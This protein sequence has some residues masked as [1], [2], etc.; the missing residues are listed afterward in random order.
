MFEWLSDPQAWIA[1][2]T[3]T[4][5]EI[6]LGVDNVIFISILAGKLPKNQQAKARR[7]GLILAMVMRILLLFS[8][9]W[10]I[11]L[12]APWFSV[13]GQDISGRDLILLLGGLFLLAKATHEIHDKLEGEEGHGSAK[14]A[15]SF[16]SVIIQIMLL[17]IVFSLDSVITAVGM[18]DDL[19][20][21]VAAVVIAVG[22]M[23][24]SAGAISG[25]VDRHPT[26]KILALSFLI[27]IGVSLIAEAFEQH[28][29]KGYIYFAMAFSVFVEMINLR[30]RT[31][32][33][34]VQ[35]HQPYVKTK[36]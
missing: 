5:L 14:V 35:L 16:M 28:I 30:V 21:M 4:V 24:M 26:V 20:V 1:L 17:D 22:V 8:I 18:A 2:S 34:P 31:K 27:L 32:G 33:A 29:P 15:A 9:A 10:I 23:M 3:L 11:R 13:F 6:V 12:T 7:V 19:A 25:F 36:D